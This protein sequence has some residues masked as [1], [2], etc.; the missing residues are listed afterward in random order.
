M[1]TERP[2]RLCAAPGIGSPQD[3]GIHRDF[4]VVRR[5]RGQG[6]GGS[7]MVLLICSFTASSFCSSRM[8]SRSPDF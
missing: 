1:T 6:N 7:S 8:P 4:A 3:S 2:A 5:E